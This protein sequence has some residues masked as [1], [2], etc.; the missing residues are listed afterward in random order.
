MTSFFL[1][2]F[3]ICFRLNS[4]C[5]ATFDEE[6][7]GYIFPGKKDG[8]SSRPRAR[9]CVRQTLTHLSI[10]DTREEEDGVLGGSHATFARRGRRRYVFPRSSPESVAPWQDPMACNRIPA[11]GVWVLAIGRSETE[12][13]GRAIARS[14]DTGGTG[15]RRGRATVATRFVRAS[16]TRAQRRR[17]ARVSPAPPHP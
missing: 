8:S 7:S 17:R 15:R 9:S 14:V 11:S 5:F 2:Q 10:A 12:G 6:P 16:P 4:H 13:D 1:V 3:R